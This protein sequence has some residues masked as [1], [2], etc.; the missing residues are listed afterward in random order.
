MF[1]KSAGYSFDFSVHDYEV[2]LPGFLLPERYTG[3]AWKVHTMDP[4]D[5][6]DEPL[7][8]KLIAKSTRKVEPFGGKIDYDIDGRLSGNWF[9]DGTVDYSGNVPAGTHEYWSGHLAIAYDP[10]DPAQVRISIGA[11][12]GIDTDI[13]RV[14]NGVYAV[15]GN[16]P[17]PA[18][19]GPDD[20]VVSYVLV[21]MVHADQGTG[22]S[23][24]RSRTLP[25][26][27]QVLG[28]LL[29][30]LMDDRTLRFEVFP[31]QASAPGFTDAAS[32]YRR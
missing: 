21:G 31:G 23:L 4:F 15:R 7:R 1:A 8:S 5:Y 26:E 30:Q 16:A 11:D 19:V 22:T 13:C 28:T 2:T 6:Y 3:E 29:V 9:L 18:G 10:I 14:C 20:G 32:I 17:D 12:V 27:S 24:F 25:V